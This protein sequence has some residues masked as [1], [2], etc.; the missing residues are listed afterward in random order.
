MSTLL[1]NRS[2]KRSIKFMDIPNEEHVTYFKAWLRRSQLDSSFMR[3]SFQFDSIVDKN[4]VFKRY[5]PKG[6][7]CDVLQIDP[8]YSR[9]KIPYEMVCKIRYNED[10]KR[11]DEQFHSEIQ[12]L[13][14]SQTS[15]I[16]ASYMRHGIHD[17]VASLSQPP[18]AAAH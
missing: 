13:V 11:Y 3:N 4:S 9:F 15:A 8:S 2:T 5:E 18:G 12:Q 6:D 17:L 10:K 7:D 16:E 1:R 14:D